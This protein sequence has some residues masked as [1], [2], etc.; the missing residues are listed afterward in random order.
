MG[1][2]YPIKKNASRMG[3]CNGRWSIARLGKFACIGL[4]AG[5]LW[6]LPAAGAET[7]VL[8]GEGQLP[9]GDF[10]VLT[11]LTINPGD[12]VSWHYHTGLGLRVVVGGTLTEDEGCGNPLI[13]HPAGSAFEEAAGHVHQ[14]F[15]LGTDPVVVLRTDILPPCYLH[16]GTI[17]VTGPSCEGD[18]G[19]SH[20][21]P[22]EPCPQASN[23]GAPKAKSPL[24]NDG[25]KERVVSS[26]Q[27][28]VLGKASASRRVGTLAL[29]TLPQPQSSY[30]G[31]ETQ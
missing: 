30:R 23:A 28:P 5:L 24:A 15:N 11:Q 31:Q 25:Q 12:T 20:L 17:F 6:S 13:P 14:L 21:V 9:S 8:L 16:K 2:N 29:A 7:I 10:I 18:S 1:V 3:L 4:T 27:Q 19:R 22:I 26:P